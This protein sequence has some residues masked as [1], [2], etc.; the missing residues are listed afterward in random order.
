MKV[1]SIQ[2]KSFS[3]YCYLAINDDNRC[4]IID[5]GCD[6]SEVKKVLEK[7]NL[8]PV[9]V[10][11][12]HCHYDHVYGVKSAREAKIPVYISSAD[13]KRLESQNGTLAS[14]VGVNYQPIFDYKV[15]F[16]GVTDFDGFSVRT[17][18][19]PGHTKGSV[20]YII[21]EYMF[22]GDT[23]F[24]GTVGRTDLPSGSLDDLKKSVNRLIALLLE[25]KVNY[26]IYPGHG[27]C[28]DL[29]TEFKTNPYFLEYK[30]D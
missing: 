20:I 22:S 6:F 14:Y 3:S 7:E 2:N 29:L 25:E 23:V 11:L 5:L 28:T 10:L 13:C 30:N 27:D 18:F 12:T 8:T 15:I 16:E 21:D 1:I 4:I 26:K 19:T 24:L 17:V 9:A